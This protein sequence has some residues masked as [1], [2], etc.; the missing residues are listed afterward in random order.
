[1]IEK[2]KMDRGKG[3]GEDSEDE[4]FKVEDLQESSNSK[5]LASNWKNRFK[6]LRNYSSLDTN[7]VSVRN[8][9]QGRDSTSR[10][11]RRDHC[12]GFV[13]HPDN[14]SV[15]VLKNIFF[16]SVFQKNYMVT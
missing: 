2:Y 6:L 16:K 9:D 3:R 1:M 13:I 7:N 10:G 11:G 4:E 8:G 5:K 12:Y 15:T 14:W